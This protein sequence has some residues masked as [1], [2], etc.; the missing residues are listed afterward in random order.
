[1]LST[2]ISDLQYPIYYVAGPPGM[3]S[4]AYQT[5]VE[6]AVP[7]ENI[8]IEHFTGYRESGKYMGVDD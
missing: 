2:H 8:R 5:L 6:L 7:E 4:G 3:V 1:M